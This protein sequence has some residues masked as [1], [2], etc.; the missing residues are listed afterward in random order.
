MRSESGVAAPA[1]RSFLARV[2][3]DLIGRF[4]RLFR[5]PSNDN[6]NIYP[7]F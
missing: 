4:R 7:F 5:K 1:G 6:P 2:F 3:G